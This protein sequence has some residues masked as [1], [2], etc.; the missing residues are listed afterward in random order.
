[1]AAFRSESVFVAIGFVGVLTVLSAAMAIAG[2]L[3]VGEAASD[4]EQHAFVAGTLL[5]VG[6]AATYLSLSSAFAGFIAGVTWS[7]AGNLAR[8]RIVRDL[9]YV[10]HPFIVLALLAAGATATV[11]LDGLLVAWALAVTVLVVLRVT[12]QFKWRATTGDPSP[13]TPLGVVAIAL[14][15]D[16]SR[17]DARPEWALTLLGGTV[18]VAVAAGLVS[19]VRVGRA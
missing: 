11:S 7:L 9:D 8:A 12:K 10:Q 1:V 2:W 14:A 15:L 5:L 6:G 13:T 3:L 4:G 17:S 18:I 16:A 19:S